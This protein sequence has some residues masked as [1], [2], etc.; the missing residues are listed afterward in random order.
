M[1]RVPRT[2]IVLCVVVSALAAPSVV[3]ADHGEPYM[4]A[5]LE[6]YVEIAQAHWDVPAPSCTGADGERIPAHTVLY[7]NPDPDVVAKA[8]QP[9]CRMWLDR[10]FWPA[11]PSRIACTIIAHEWG[12]LLGHGHSADTN[13]LMY[14]QP[15][16][17]APGCS[18][19]DP[20]VTLGTAVAHSSARARRRGLRQRGKRAPK[21][22]RAGRG[23]RARS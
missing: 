7:D 20:R 23:V 19:Y 4:D 2:L 10:D 8:E 18:L 14:V 6:S 16:T 5:D 15:L 12:H 21:G 11:P 1:P 13:D 9:G 3:R 22:S 17:G